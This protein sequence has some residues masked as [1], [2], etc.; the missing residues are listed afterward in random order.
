MTVHIRAVLICVWKAGSHERMYA[1]QLTC[2]YCT[3]GM[4]TLNLISMAEEQFGG[5]REWIEFIR[6]L[7]LCA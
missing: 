1:C 6:V 2:T 3:E 4:A 5:R 7:H